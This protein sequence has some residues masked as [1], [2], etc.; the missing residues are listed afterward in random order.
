MRTPSVC[1]HLLPRLLKAPVYR[2]RSQAGAGWRCRGVRCPLSIP[3][4]SN[5]CAHKVSPSSFLSA[6]C[7]VKFQFVG[8]T[9]RPMTGQMK[10]TSLC[11]HFLICNMRI[12][13]YLFQIKWK[14]SHKAIAQWLAHSRCLVNINFC[15]SFYHFYYGLERLATFSVYCSKSAV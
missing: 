5:T 12:L 7:P 10:Q 2:V 1:Q 8:Q 15:Y 11:L 6:F 14:N 4:S 13:K 3:R 9:G